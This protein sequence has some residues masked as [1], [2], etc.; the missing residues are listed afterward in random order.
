MGHGALKRASRSFNLSSIPR[1]V[2]SLQS[3]RFQ[4][5]QVRSCVMGPGGRPLAAAGGKGDGLRHCHLDKLIF[6][7]FLANE[8]SFSRNKSNNQFHCV[9]SCTS[10]SSEK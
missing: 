5:M 4:I 6:T 3:L 1:V 8:K 9:I 7:P 2:Q 10:N